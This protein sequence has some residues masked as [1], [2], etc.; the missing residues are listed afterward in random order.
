MST[1]HIIARPVRPF[2]VPNVS[3]TLA[4]VIFVRMDILWLILTINAKNGLFSTAA[5]CIKAFALSV[6]A[7]TC[8][9]KILSA[10]L[11]LFHAK[12]KTAQFANLLTLHNVR[13]VQTDILLTHYQKSARKSSYA[14][15]KTV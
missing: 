3:I 7:A 13:L 12:S 14:T 11:R 5:S 6:I 10:L 4:Y 9:I 2:S 1:G 8:L 15:S